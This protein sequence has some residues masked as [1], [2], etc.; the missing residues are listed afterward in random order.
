M[1]AIIN[2]YH[3]IRYL[4]SGIAFILINQSVTAAKTDIGM[5]CWSNWQQAIKVMHSTKKPILVISVP[6]SVSTLSVLSKVFSEDNKILQE[7]MA[8]YIPVCVS[9]HFF[10][11]TLQDSDRNLAVISVDQKT[12]QFFRVNL[13]GSDNAISNNIRKAIYGEDLKQIKELDKSFSK[14]LKAESRKAI[15]DALIQLNNNKYKKR[16]KAKVYLRKHFKESY[17]AI[18]FTQLNAI[19]VE[20]SESCKEILREKFRK[21]KAKI[22]GKS[23][24]DP[25]NYPVDRSII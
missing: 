17:M 8:K 9:D 7:L 15:K 2:R 11:Y 24:L 16:L 5:S 20:Q 6:N 21:D 3:I 23:I 13:S 10:R 14:D 4:V 19:S 22:F 25:D 18:L 12:K 1:R